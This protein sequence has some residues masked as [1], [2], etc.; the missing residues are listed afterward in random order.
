MKRVCSLPVICVAACLAFMP[1]VAPAGPAPVGK[2]ESGKPSNQPAESVNSPADFSEEVLGKQRAVMLEY[3]TCIT[4]FLENALT[5]M[6]VTHAEAILTAGDRRNAVFC[7]ADCRGSRTGRSSGCP[8]PRHWCWNNC[9]QWYAW[10]VSWC[11]GTVA[12]AS[13]YIWHRKDRPSLCR[14][15]QS[16][17]QSR[18]PSLPAWHTH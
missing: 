18:D 1:S 8:C 4:A 3:Q 9:R 13:T 7:C 5:D 17:L 2:T 15:K 14:R 10:D 16:A 11:A 12:F 6:E